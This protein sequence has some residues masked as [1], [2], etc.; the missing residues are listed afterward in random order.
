MSSIDFG[1]YKRIVQMIWDPE[2]VNDANIDLP[3]WCLG[4]AYTLQRTTED[5]AADET[6][7]TTPSTATPSNAA[8]AP[9]PAPQPDTSDDTQKQPASTSVQPQNAPD[10]LGVDSITSS[11]SSS[12]VSDIPLG[13]ASGWPPAFISDFESRIWM[14]YR[15]EF[16]PIP[17]SPDP[18]AF[19]A[20]SISMRIKSQL[21]DHNGFTS[22]SGW[23]CMIR[24]GQSLLANA[25]L[26]Q[27]LG[28]D[29]RRGKSS[30]EERK[31]LSLF[32]D[33][34]KAPYSIHSFVQHGATACGKFPG[35]WF[36]PSATASC[37]KALTATHD[38]PL[39]VYITGDSPEIDE[40]AFIRTAKADGHTFK[41]TLILVGTRLGTDKITTVYWEGLLATLQ[42]TQSVGIAGGRPSSSHYFIGTQGSHLFYL[43]PHHTRKAL[44]YHEDPS[45]YDDTDIDSCHTSRLRCLHIKDMDPSMLIGFLIRD[46]EDWVD[47]KNALGRIRS[48]APVVLAGQQHARSGAAV[49]R[50]SAIDEVE[51]LSDENDEA[52]TTES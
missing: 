30:L 5:K 40:D 22:D 31:L 27:Q 19:S 1:P 2:P 48:M 10:S 33:D 17:K 49:E 41:P 13:S 25:M 45:N 38:S 28:R 8:P 35:E 47:W 18:K 9:A 50:A 52:D 29:W 12:L 21:M 43:D 36:G 7:A 3:V 23:G 24:S 11:F 14:T 46:E 4:R 20:L 26:I 39:C 15:S 44:A 6:R 42:M 34:P 51:S 37:I 16:V 32:A